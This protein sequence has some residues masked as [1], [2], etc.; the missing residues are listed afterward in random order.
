[1]SPWEVYTFMVQTTW[2]TVVHKVVTEPRVLPRYDI[3]EPSV[4]H[5]P[6]SHT[7]KRPRYIG[8]PEVRRGTWPKSRTILRS[9]E[10][11]DPNVYRCHH[12][13]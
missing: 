8:T 5:P 9:R 12:N 13:P 11:I 1:M 2:G 10:D 3:V 7:R 4:P 6:G